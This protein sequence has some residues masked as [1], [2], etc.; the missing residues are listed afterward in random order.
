MIG[1]LIAILKRRPVVK[2]LPKSAANARDF[3]DTL[4]DLGGRLDRKEI[5]KNEFLFTAEN[6]LK[7]LAEASFLEGAGTKFFFDTESEQYLSDWVR[8]QAKWLPGLIDAIKTNGMDDNVRRRLNLWGDSL[9]AVGG[10]GHIMANRDVYGT[11]ISGDTNRSCDTC[12][13]LN[14]VRKPLGWFLDHG[15]IPGQPGSKSLSCGGWGC[16]CRIV[17]DEEKRLLPIVWRWQKKPRYI[18]SL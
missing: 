2:S 4:S 3:L 7:F 1:A 15:Y 13:E 18:T 5:S 8:E 6:E 14:G 11:W 9:A 17:D 12:D 10:I 16:C